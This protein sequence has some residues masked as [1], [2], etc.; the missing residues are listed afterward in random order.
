MK[1]RPF[2]VQYP[3]RGYCIVEVNAVSKKQAKERVNKGHVS[4]EAMISEITWSGKANKVNDS[5]NE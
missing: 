1:E 5:K 3:I 4:I 2:I